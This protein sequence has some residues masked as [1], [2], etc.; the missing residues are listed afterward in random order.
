MVV[1]TAIEQV[2]KD[3]KYKPSDDDYKQAIIDAI[4]S[5][6]V[7]GVT[8]TIK[9]DGTGDPVKPTLV[10]TFKDGKESVFDTIEAS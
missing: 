1:M 4:A 9:Y 3:G 2:E 7:D 6:S 10:I 8:G 5:G